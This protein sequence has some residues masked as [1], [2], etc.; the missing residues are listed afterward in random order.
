MRAAGLRLALGSYLSLPL[1]PA[2]P[3]ADMCTGRS[4]LALRSRATR[5][6]AASGGAVRSSAQRPGAGLSG[7]FHYSKYMCIQPCL[8]DG[9]CD[10]PNCFGAHSF[11]FG[12]HAID[13]RYAWFPDGIL[14][15]PLIHLA[16]HT[17]WPDTLHGCRPLLTAA[18]VQACSAEA[19]VVR[20]PCW[21]FLP[22]HQLPPGAPRGSHSY[23]PC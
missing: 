4:I 14:Q 6:H 9:A 10:L 3:Q 1:P 5:V 20:A 16:R 12:A 2:A 23:S 11:R 17:A 15:A 18:V 22:V 8:T 7:E 21:E 13:I 19:R